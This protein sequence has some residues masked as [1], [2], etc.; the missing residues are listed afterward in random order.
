MRLRVTREYHL[1]TAGERADG[2]SRIEPG[3]REVIRA[4]LIGGRGVDIQGLKL[5]TLQAGAPDAGLDGKGV[6]RAV[7]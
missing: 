3:N 4:G 1:A 5:A 6:E 7:Q 2:A